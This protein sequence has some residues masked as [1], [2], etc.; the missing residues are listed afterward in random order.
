MIKTYLARHAQV[1][2]FTLGQMARTPLATLMT[3]GM[4]AIAIALPTGL[5]ITVDNIQR[6]GGGHEGQARISLFLK[7]KISADQAAQLR[8]KLASDAAIISA[9]HLSPDAALDEFKRSSGLGD[10]AAALDDNPLPSVIIL[11]PGLSDPDAIARLA[12]RLGKHPAVELAQLDLKWIK[13]LHALLMLAQRAVAILALVLALAVLLIIGNTIRLAVAARHDEIE[14]IQLV[15]GSDAFIRRPFLYSGMLHAALGALL[16][17][18]LVSLVLAL[19]SAPLAELSGLYGS[20]FRLAGLGL[21]NGTKLIAAAAL[22][23]WIGAFG[24]TTRELYRIAPR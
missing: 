10:M 6:L 23:G 21:L 17:W 9:R 2:F 3:L 7:H 11:T 8:A 16:A 22:V 12:E 5:Y 20:D 1:F 4:I 15:G 24:A 14:V 19:L 18:M 13:R